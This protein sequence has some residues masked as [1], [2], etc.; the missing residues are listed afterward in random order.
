MTTL[1]VALAA[2]AGVAVLWAVVERGR[3]IAAETRI[4][5]A[6][7]ESAGAA[8]RFLDEAAEQTERAE[9]LAAVLAQRDAHIAELAAIVETCADPRIAYERLA[10]ALTRGSS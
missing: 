10:R 7:A 1:L 9:R 3:R 4:S 5:E 2:C 8:S 6:L